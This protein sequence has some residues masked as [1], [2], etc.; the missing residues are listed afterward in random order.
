MGFD[1]CTSA[2]ALA[3]CAAQ[4]SAAT[5][6]PGAQGR[7]APVGALAGQE[8]GHGERAPPPP[9]RQRPQEGV[10]VAAGGTGRRQGD[11]KKARMALADAIRAEAAHRSVIHG[12]SIAHRAAESQKKAVCSLVAMPTLLPAMPAMPTPTVAG[13]Q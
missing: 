13:N 3:E 8:G 9:K 1:I 4:R 10:E 12:H 2:P 6:A 7:G 5:P 11:A